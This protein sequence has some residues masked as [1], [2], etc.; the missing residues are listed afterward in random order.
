MSTDWT[1]VGDLH[2][3]NNNREKVEKLFDW[4]EE[5][6]KNVIFMGD[7]FDTKEIIHGKIFNY[8]RHRLKI[9]KLTFVID[10]GNHDWFNLDCLEH[11]LESLKDL[12]NVLVVDRPLIVD[13]LGIVMPYYQ[14]LAKFRKD[15]DSISKNGVYTL[16]MHQ[17]F[18]GFDYGNG[19]M[20][21]GLGHGELEADDLKNLLQRFRRIISGHFH[22]YAAEGNFMFIGTPFSQ[23]FG[24][25]DQ[26][27]FIASYNSETDELELMETPFPRHRTLTM[28]LE[29]APSPEENLRGWLDQYPKDHW[30]LRLIG[31]EMQIAAF[32]KASFPAVK[33]LDEPTDADQIENANI[34]DTDSN[35]QKFLIW[36][37][38]IKGLDEVT[39]S[40]GLEILKAS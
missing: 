24:E 10:V 20:A 28:N 36:A 17:G 26:T 9:S 30:R 31:T 3:D 34:K 2:A 18:A 27:K 35:E 22:K 29:T 25:T 5:L 11:S 39:I 13:G 21:D 33:F 7:L 37:K 12:P 4:L 1:V 8:I 40:E 15:L 19:H 16:F 32:D 38:E 6:G 14:D 23:D